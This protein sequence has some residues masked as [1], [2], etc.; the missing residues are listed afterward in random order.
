VALVLLV[1]ELAAWVGLRRVQAITKHSRVAGLL[2][3]RPTFGEEQVEQTFAERDPVLGWPTT[4]QLASRRYEPDGAR[5]GPAFG[6]AQPAC[7]AAFGDSFTY[8]Q[9]VNDADAWANRLSETLGCR[10]ANFG[11]AGYGVDQAYLRYQRKQDLLGA[12]RAVVIG[13]FP[14]NIMRHV[15]Q[16]V[17]LRVARPNLLFKPR[18]VVEAGRLV[19]YPALPR[20]RF[21]PERIA[22]SPAEVFP[23]EF[24]LPGSRYGP[25]PLRFPYTLTAARALLHPRVL[26]SVLGQPNWVDFYQEGFAASDG[27]E[28]TAALL[29]AFARDVTASGKAPLVFV[30]TNAS[31]VT[32]YLEE[33]S[34]PYQAVLDF[35]LEAGIPY[36][37]VGPRF[38]ETF[39]ADRICEVFTRETLFGCTG[40]YTPEG[41]A[42]VA[43]LIARQ[44]RNQ[45][46]FPAGP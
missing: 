22:E 42:M 31:S 27:M 17:G 12:A 15:N 28:V 25:V 5:P 32:A 2:W 38:A 34:W 3:E 44:L 41:Y 36:V 9:E 23:H 40:H 19:L 20:D 16:Y 45:G 24:F 11:V 7:A 18:F 46:V 33:A 39:G 26:A 10:V 13:F 29:Q 37:H 8:A 30:F 6:S 21:D 14:E 1:M 35:M 43:D 4:S